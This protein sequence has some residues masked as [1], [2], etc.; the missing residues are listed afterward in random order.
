M[1]CEDFEYWLL[2]IYDLFK[3]RF[4]KYLNELC[5]IND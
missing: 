1:V 3:C 2:I 5:M 4:F